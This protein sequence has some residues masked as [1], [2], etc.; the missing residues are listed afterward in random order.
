MKCFEVWTGDDS[1]GYECYGVV[2]ESELKGIARKH[3]LR[4]R[5]VGDDGA[6][7]RGSSWQWM[8]GR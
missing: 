7:V 4:A 6:Y 2:E 8:G 5:E 3:E 1:G